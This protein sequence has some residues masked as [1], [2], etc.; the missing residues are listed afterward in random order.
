MRSFQSLGIYGFVEDAVPES[1]VQTVPHHQVDLAA[2]YV[3]D[4]FLQLQEPEYTPSHLVVVIDEDIDIAVGAM[5]A[6]PAPATPASAGM[7]RP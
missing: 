6:S 5:R 3:L 2:K 7:A 1:S 4:V